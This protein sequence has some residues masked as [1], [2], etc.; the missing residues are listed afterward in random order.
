MRGYFGVGV[1]NLSKAYNAGALYRTAH[2]FGANFVFAFGA[3][4]PAGLLQRV[5]TSKVGRHVPFYCYD[6][7]EELVLPEGC[8]LVGVELCEFARELPEFEHPSRAVYIFGPERGDLSPEILRHCHSVIKIPTRFCLNV[9]IACAVVMYDRKLS[10]GN[11]RA[12]RGFG[13]TKTNLESNI[14][15]TIE[16]ETARDKFN[17]MGGRTASES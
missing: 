4:L 15:T 7:L 16:K 3:N 9:G 13:A 11:W 5:D 1:A 14:D 17:G 12:R 8:A 2:A 10:L 6:R